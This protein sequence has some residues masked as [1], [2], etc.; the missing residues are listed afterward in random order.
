MWKDTAIFH[1]YDEW[2]GFYDHVPPPRLDGF[3]LG[4]RVATLT[5]SPYAKRG[6]IDHTVGEF[7]SM[8]K[9]V[10]ANWDLT[11]LTNRDR[12]AEDLSYNFD[13]DQKPRDPDPLPLRTDCGAKKPDIPGI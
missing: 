11:H 4:I 5:I 6:F 1:T 8:L 9:F 13:F 12:R 2:G 7:S 3:G 10:E